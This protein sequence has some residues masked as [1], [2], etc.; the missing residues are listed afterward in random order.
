[1]ALVNGGAGVLLTDAEC[2]GDTLVAQLEPLLA[3]PDRLEAMSRA[4]RALARPD[5]A[6]ALADLVEEAAK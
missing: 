3:D 1:M 5:A 4:G 2:N 6:D